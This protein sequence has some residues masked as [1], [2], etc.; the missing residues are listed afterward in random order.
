MTSLPGECN[1]VDGGMKGKVS[2]IQAQTTCIS[3]SR[4]LFR[5][6]VYSSI[7]NTVPV[8]TSDESFYIRILVRNY[9]KDLKVHVFWKKK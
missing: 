8:F 5:F 1:E 7:V 9:Y 3:Y 6:P 4:C 2:A